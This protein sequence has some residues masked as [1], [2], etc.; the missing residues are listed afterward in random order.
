MITIFIRMHKHF[1]TELQRNSYAVF[2]L[3][4]FI[5]RLHYDNK[6][7]PLIDYMI[8]FASRRYFRFSHTVWNST[9]FMALISFSS[10]SVLVIALSSRRGGII[11]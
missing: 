1:L 3:I 5:I 10:R 9:L 4:V 7:P 2:P 6:L 11:T 8:S